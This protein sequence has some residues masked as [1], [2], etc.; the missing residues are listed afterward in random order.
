[1]KTD[2]VIMIGASADNDE[3]ERGRSD[4]VPSRTAAAKKWAD[5]NLCDLIVP[6]ADGGELR[7]PS[8]KKFRPS[9]RV[10]PR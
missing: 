10:A 2:G 9:G 6:V 1:M 4:A 7:F 5:R 3:P 8:S